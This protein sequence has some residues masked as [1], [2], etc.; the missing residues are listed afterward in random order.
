MRAGCYSSRGGSSFKVAGV[1]HFL[2]LLI[3]ACLGAASAGWLDRVAPLL[4]PSDRAAYLSLPAEAR[5]E[6]EKQFW[7]GKAI[8]AEEYFERVTFVDSHFGGGKPGSGANTDQG[9]A[10]LTLGA[11]NR[12][13]RLP[14]SRNFVPLEIWYY[15]ASPALNTS[16]E[17][18][19]MFFLK[20]SQ[21]LYKLY[22]PTLNTIRDLLV[23]Q[24]GLLG[25]FGPNDM[26]SEA[27]IRT[28]LNSTAAEDEV[29]SAAASVAM[30]I[31]GAGNDEI[32]ARAM[33]PRLALTRPLH[34]EVQSRLIAFHPKLEFLAS[35]GPYGGSQIDLV[36]ETKVRRKLRLEVLLEGILVYQKQA[37]FA[38]DEARAIRYLHRL[39]LLPGRYRVMLSVDDKTA[40]YPLDVG[41]PKTGDIVVG[42]RA[43]ES[44]GRETPFEFGNDHLDPGPGGSLAVLPL[45]QPTAVEWILRRGLEVRWKHTTAPQSVSV[46]ELPLDRIEP[47]RY[48]LEATAGE[49][50]RSVD[51]VMPEPRPASAVILVSDNANL[52][53][54]RRLAFLG[55]QWL[56][57]GESA[58]ALQTLQASL[59]KG[60]S[61]E[62]QIEMSRAQAF[63]GRY[64]EARD[65]LRPILSAQPN[66]FE[67]LTALAFIEAKLQDY[68]VA[69]ELYQRALG[70]QDSAAVRL[71]LASLPQ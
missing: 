46:V 2:L 30:G 3:P 38:F 5:P 69:R 62:A 40:A 54:A 18:R 55:R 27:D 4:T 60:P 61:S 65:W 17:V 13:M 48:K 1:R 22:S 68:V 29:V 31:T 67:A 57:R 19:L 21:G 20:N 8:S 71:A 56:V 32:L 64:D 50:F 44:D 11:P 66:N 45:A 14:S 36:A 26:I 58:K 39:D 10:Y 12:I 37:E 41:E 52:A 24:A 6:F 59:A 70:V 49:V 15:E 34:P 33:A 16:A 28:K 47:G 7:D 23:P 63:A 35:P 9:R 42:S 43:R 51:L 25:M 53:P